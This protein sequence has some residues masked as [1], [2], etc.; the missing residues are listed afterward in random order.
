MQKN[1]TWPLE[2]IGDQLEAFRKAHFAPEMRLIAP[3]P[4]GIFIG[5]YDK[6]E[7]RVVDFNVSHAVVDDH[8]YYSKPD[9]PTRAFHF[10][11]QPRG[12]WSQPEH[13]MFTFDDEGGFLL[14]QPRQ[15]KYEVEPPVYAAFEQLVKAL[16]EE[17]TK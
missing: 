13:V 16:K 4:S 17:V 11:F 12:T 1:H 6:L 9:V 5:N 15:F 2:A 3:L 8:H 10:I 14:N 7:V